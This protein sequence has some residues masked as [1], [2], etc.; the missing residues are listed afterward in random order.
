MA[1]T[2]DFIKIAEGIRSDEISS[3]QRIEHLSSE[4]S[5]VVSSINHAQ[6]EINSLEA[7]ISAEMSTP[8]ETDSEG[9]TYGG[10]DYNAITNMQAQIETYQREINTLSTQRAQLEGERDTERQHLQ[11]VLIEKSATLNEVQSKAQDVATSV[12]AAGG[13]VGAYSGIGS[14]LANSFQK[15]HSNLS[16]A[17]GIL[18]GSVSGV[19]AG[20]GG[21]AN[22]G[23]SVAGIRGVPS[24]T[25]NS[26]AGMIT[27]GTGGGGRSTSGSSK[28]SASGA[29]RG[30]QTNG[31]ARGSSTAGKYSTSQ[32]STAGTAFGFGT[33]AGNE[34]APLN[35]NKFS[36]SKTSAVPSSFSSLFKRYLPSEESFNWIDEYGKKGQRGNSICSLKDDMKYYYDKKKGIKMSG[37]EIK[38][39]WEEKYGTSSVRYTN[40][41][42]DFTPFVDNYLGAVHSDKR[43]YQRNGNS[44]EEGTFDKANKEVAMRWAMRDG[45]TKEEALNR[46]IEY[47]NRVKNYMTE[48]HLTWHECGDIDNYTILPIPSEI[49]GIFPHTGGIAFSLEFQAMS[50]IL[51]DR[52]G[53]RAII[54]RKFHNSTVSSDEI[55]GFKQGYLNEIK[56][57]MKRIDNFGIIKVPKSEIIDGHIPIS[58]LQKHYG[59][60]QESKKK[61][62]KRSVL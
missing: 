19:S 45:L 3:K 4:I 51:R 62:K 48:N 54:S 7:S 1:S 55:E 39:M 2:A 50:N 16:Q 58:V 14:N 34:T 60:D 41:E 26:A 18:G 40:E 38:K 36:T 43:I 15:A 42:P 22:S 13:M 53:N 24:Q 12:A 23:R 52:I 9:N 17:A 31:T 33:G 28:L 6:S 32:S 8:Y 25:R 47:V 11:E 59:N 56:K 57:E 20:G 46:Q 35:A 27:H 44:F 5:G 10:P 30:V 21:G 37:K 29:S 61:G 49:N